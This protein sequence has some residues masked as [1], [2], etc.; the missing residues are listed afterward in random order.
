MAE[1]V[2]R[3]N[4]IVKELGDVYLGMSQSYPRFFEQL[5]GELL[6]LKEGESGNTTLDNVTAHVEA[7]RQG[8][9]NFSRE[10]S[11]REGELIET[12]DRELKKLSHIE[13]GIGGMEE[14]SKDLEL[15]SLNAMVAALKAGNNGGAFPYIT[16][17]L[18]RVSRLAMESSNEIRQFGLNL[19]R[20]YM[21]L[22][23]QVKSGQKETGKD[24]SQIYETLESLVSRLVFY[25]KAFADQ[26]RFLEGGVDKIRSPLHMILEE[27]QKHDIVR[28]SVDHIILSLEEVHNTESGQTVE[29]QLNHLKFSEQAYELS[30]FII[31]DIRESVQRSFDRFSTEKKDVEEIIQTLN[32][33]MNKKAREIE[34][35]D[36]GSQM[37]HIRKS[38]T[39][40]F[41]SRNRGNTVNHMSAEQFE[42]LTEDLEDG[43][44]LFT[45]VLNSIRNIHVASRIE[46]VK[47]SK[48]ENMENI[49]NSIDD[50]VGEMESL[51]GNIG[52]SVDDFKKASS[53]IVTDFIDYFKHVKSQ[54]EESF[55]ELDPILAAIE[56]FQ[57]ELNE[58]FTSFARVNRDFGDFSGLIEEHLKNM[59]ALIKEMDG[60]SGEFGKAQESY[61][62]K[63]Q[64][65]LSRSSYEEWA[66][67]GEL[68]NKLI[69]KF[70]IFIHK[71][72]LSEGGESDGVVLDDEQ[73]GASEITL[74]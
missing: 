32:R 48:L 46:V 66:L 72:A 31:N 39:L 37:V 35:D 68:I 50:T 56:E 64:K 59:K 74:F 29:E 45:K 44:A 28:Q 33:E 70:T 24:I 5:D 69:D 8:K 15:T 55:N 21:S 58:H 34:T 49:I 60:I 63:L 41:S 57:G 54:M 73:A 3:L 71:K 25:E 43:I 26:C 30:Q 52:D 19:D 23:D 42:E 18:Q 61:A 22:I 4:R 51:L 47:L 67:E 13:E 6:C 20:E 10:N 1:M 27:V 53:L 14:C 38:L 36:M 62:N 16:R 9:S 65:E 17:E 40:Y 2:E 11:Q 7:F 12:I